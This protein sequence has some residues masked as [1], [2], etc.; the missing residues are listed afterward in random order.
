[1]GESNRQ[2]IQSSNMK[3]LGLVL[4]LSLLMSAT[5]QPIFLEAP[6]AAAAFTA[7]GG[8]V[9]SSAAGATLLTYPLPLLSPEKCCWRQKLLLLVAFWLRQLQE[10]TTT[11]DAT[12]TERDSEIL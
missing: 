5:A 1:M 4:S 11:T 8:L 10:T 3:F 12:D 6:I 2:P 9:L 7:S